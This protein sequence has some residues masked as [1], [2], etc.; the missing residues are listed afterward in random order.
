MSDHPLSPDRSSGGSAAGENRLGRFDGLLPPPRTVP[1]QVR[2]RLMLFYLDRC[3]FVYVFATMAMFVGLFYVLLLG[4]SWTVTVVGARTPEVV[5]SDEL[6]PRVVGGVLLLLAA[7]IW[8][9]CLVV[10]L[11]AAG[12]IIRVLT[13]GEPADGR[14]DRVLGG[15]RPPQYGPWADLIGPLARFGFRD[16]PGAIGSLWPIKVILGAPFG[17]WPVKFLVTDPRGPEQE[18]DGRMNLEPWLDHVVADPRVSL[19]ADRLSQCFGENSKG[20]VADPRVSLLVDRRRDPATCVIPEQFAWLT[21]SD[22]GGL[23]V[24]VPPRVPPRSGGIGSALAEALRVVVPTYCLSALGLAFVAQPLFALPRDP[25]IPALKSAVLVVLFTLT[26]GVVP[27]FFYQFFVQ[28]LQVVT[29]RLEIAGDGPPRP[30]P[31][32]RLM[33]GFVHL[34]MVVWFG[35]PMILLGALSGWIS[36]AW[37]LLHVLLAAPGRR[38]WIFLEYGSTSMA[39]ALFILLFSGKALVPLGILV[40]LFQAG[41]LTIVEWKGKHL[42]FPP[43]PPA[44]GRDREDG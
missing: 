24:R 9:V 41:L 36:L 4:D 30:K 33:S 12:K 37:G 14:I 28:V 38:R 35:A 40:A 23:T 19:L 6:S 25:E 2:W 13:W 22:S 10:A 1:A 20:L 42:W 43:A 16:R 8:S 31:L 17:N 26:H 27:V 34:H 15:G 5:D 18:I 32:A 7:G 3:R 11:L 29:R 21:R 44:A 39:L